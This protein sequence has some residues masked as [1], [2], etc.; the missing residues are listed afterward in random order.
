MPAIC[1]VQDKFFVMS[2]DRKVKCP[3]LE[4]LIIKFVFFSA[5]LNYTLMEGCIPWEIDFKL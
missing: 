1:E 4:F 3:L 5:L 2:S